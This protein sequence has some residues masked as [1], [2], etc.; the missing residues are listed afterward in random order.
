[1]VGYFR[2][3]LWCM[4][5]WGYTETFILFNYPKKEFFHL[6][7]FHILFIIPLSHNHSTNKTKKIC[8]S[9]RIHSL[10]WATPQI[11]QYWRMTHI[12]KFSKV[13]YGCVCLWLR[14]LFFRSCRASLISQTGNFYIILF[15]SLKAIYSY[16]IHLLRLIFTLILRESA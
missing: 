14:N 13:V 12:K 16:W 15:V 7:S 8:F 5:F 3:I 4:P 1:M 6:F 9:S 11:C 10:K 2:P